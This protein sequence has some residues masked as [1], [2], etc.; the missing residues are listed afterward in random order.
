MMDSNL[1]R[2][3]GQEPSGP[4]H[5]EA[6]KKSFVRAFSKNAP[7]WLFVTPW[8]V[9]LLLF[10]LYPLVSS[11]YLSF[12]SYS[13][14]KAGQFVGLQNYQSLMQDKVFWSS[15]YNTVYY[16]LVFVPLSIVLSIWLALL[17]NTR[18]KGIAIYRTVFYLPTLVP[19]VAKA[20]LWMWL[21][22]PQ[23]GLVNQLL[24][25][26]G[27][28]GPPWL[29]NEAWAKPTLV[30][31]SL[32]A[33]GQT[34]VIFLAG[35]QGI[36]Q[37]YYDAAS[38]DGARWYQKFGLVTLP[39]LTPVIFYNLV[40]GIISSIQVFS[41]PYTLTGGSGSPAGSMMFYVM[42]LYQNAFLYLKMGYASAMA[43]I[44]F[45]VIALLTVVIF[46]SSKK[47]VHYQGD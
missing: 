38:V 33:V 23:A 27:I 16:A 40:M 13:I 32:W 46:I 10:Y 22:N 15:I 41:L 19:L 47:W 2:A 6:R 35:L 14:L 7:G 12:T 29:G 25:R 11:I 39:L 42:Y 20:V 21:L 4:R 9:G 17:L 37:E 36:S 24:S 45:I 44:L 31:I 8:I 3:T 26:L 30:M 34:V 5:Q 1:V 43:W 28:D 18:V